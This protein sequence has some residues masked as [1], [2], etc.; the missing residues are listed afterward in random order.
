MLF[1]QILVVL[2]MVVQLVLVFG[3]QFFGEDGV[4]FDGCC[5]Q[6]IMSASIEERLVDLAGG[7]WRPVGKRPTWAEVLVF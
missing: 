5:H 1:G 6:L 2:L 4:G 3:C 7:S